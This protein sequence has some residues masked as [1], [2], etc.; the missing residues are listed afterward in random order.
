MRPDWS[1]LSGDSLSQTLGENKMT[2]TQLTLLQEVFFDICDLLDSREVD[3][4]KLKS[5][6][7]FETL[8]EFLQEQKQKLAQI[9]G[10][11]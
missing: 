4:I 6:D 3:R 1:K 7:E 11:V 10:A 2:Q 8:G 9:E 5:F